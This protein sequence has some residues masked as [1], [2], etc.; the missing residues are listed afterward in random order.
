MPLLNIEYDRSDHPHRR[1]LP[2][3]A[4][5]GAY[6]AKRRSREMRRNS[7]RGVLDAF[8]GT[9]PGTT[10]A[11]FQAWHDAGRPYLPGK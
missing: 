9:F 11:D 3:V 5:T 1:I 10:G 8:F 7:L 6:R 2:H 4:Q